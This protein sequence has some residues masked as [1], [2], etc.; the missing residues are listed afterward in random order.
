MGTLIKSLFKELLNVVYPP[1]CFFCKAPLEGRDSM[2]ACPSCLQQIT[3]IERPFCTRCGKPYAQD[4]TYAHLCG[5][6]LTGRQYFR[7]ARAVGYYRGVLKEALH[8]CKYRLKRHLALPLGAIMTARLTILEEDCLPQMVIPV[9]LHPRRL[10]ARGFNQALALASAVGTHLGI[11]LDRYNLRRMRWTRSQVG[12]TGRE[13]LLNVR[14]A[15]MLKRSEGIA[16]KDI[17][18]IDDIYT[19]GSTVN[20]CSRVLVAAG[21]RQVDVLTLAR[22][23]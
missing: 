17:L 11:P 19:S 5:E 20:E 6:C 14:Q 16:G 18:L 22:V 23:A 9:P 3:Y 15:F 8:L 1:S 13:R 2:G 4:E 7:R 21:A 10:R 12:L